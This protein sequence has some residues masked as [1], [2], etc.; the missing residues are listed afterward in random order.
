M[1]RSYHALFN[2]FGTSPEVRKEFL[3]AFSS[4]VQ[5]RRFESTPEVQQVMNGIFRSITGIN[6]A[7]ATE[8][9]ESN[10]IAELLYSEWKPRIVNAEDPFTAALRLSI[11]GNIMDYGA[12]ESFDIHKTI[13]RVMREPF[14]ADYSER[15]RHD[16]RKAV[17]VLYLGDNCGEIVFDRLFLETIG[18]PKVTY[19]VRGGPALNDATLK[20]AAETG[21]HRVANV[22]HNGY[23]APSTVIKKSARAF[24]EAFRSADLII[25]KGQGNLE[26]LINERDP[27]IYF[28]LMVKCD[29]MAEK[30]DVKKGSFIVYNQGDTELNNGLYR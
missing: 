19:A 10:R 25:S 8:K 28:L 29:V 6:D 17:S 7:F 23:D 24:Q 15:L 4:T 21:M 11:A 12:A 26:G 30:L 22:V 18:H 13:E 16:L 5:T 2:K 1:L 27:R 9:A 14:A 20:E 3:N